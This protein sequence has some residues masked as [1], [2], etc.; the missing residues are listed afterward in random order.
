[1]K[2]ETFELMERIKAAL[3]TAEIICDEI[4]CNERDYNDEKYTEISVKFLK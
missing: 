2:T 1:M 3:K 4:G